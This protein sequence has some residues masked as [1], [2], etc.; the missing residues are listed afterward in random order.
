MNVAEGPANFDLKIPSQFSTF[1]SSYR[2]LANT[3]HNYTLSTSG[4]GLLNNQSNNGPVAPVGPGQYNH[5]RWHGNQFTSTA[6]SQP[7]GQVTEI[8][9]PSG[10]QTKDLALGGGS[11][12]VDSTKAYMAGVW[13]RV[14]EHA[15]NANRVSLLGESN[16]SNNKGY[17]GTTYNA[18][19]KVYG[20][21]VETDINLNSALTEWKLMSFFF[22]PDWMS[23]A[24]VRAWH[25]D[26]FGEWAGEYEFT[27]AAQQIASG[28]INTPMDARVLQQ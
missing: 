20:P 28:G 4:S 1:Y 9:S 3:S 25:D 23:V 15:G 24:E 7:H 6:N 18:N 27:T 26:Y 13:V 22:L 14:R 11:I 8:R 19:T 2:N 10:N 17:N 21:S 16:G 5:I 12:K